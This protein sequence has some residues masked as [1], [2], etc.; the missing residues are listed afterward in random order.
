[1]MLSIEFVYYWAFENCSVTPAFTDIYYILLITVIYY[2]QL[3]FGV[4][5]RQEI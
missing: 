2:I 5:R 4:I 1:M 3:L